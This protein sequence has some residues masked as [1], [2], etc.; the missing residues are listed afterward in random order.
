VALL[1]HLGLDARINKCGR[2]AKVRRISHR[3]S[4]TIAFRRFQFGLQK[5]L[6]NRLR[7]LGRRL[8][9]VNAGMGLLV[10]CTCASSECAS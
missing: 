2:R 5:D 8:A 4:Q 10:S 3:L 9:N 6:E 1:L 7:P